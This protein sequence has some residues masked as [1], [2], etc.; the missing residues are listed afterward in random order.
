MC[1]EWDLLSSCGAWASHCSGFSCEAQA[2]G[3]AGVSNVTVG[4]VVQA[5]GLN[6]CEPIFAGAH[7]VTLGPDGPHV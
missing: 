1:S 4:S 3:H 6:T 5:P 7:L 2:L